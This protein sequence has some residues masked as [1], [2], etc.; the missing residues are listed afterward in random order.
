M[1]IQKHAKNTQNTQETHREITIQKHAKQIVKTQPTHR[2]ITIHR[3][4]ETHS[5]KHIGKLQPISMQNDTESTTAPQDDDNPEAC[6]KQHAKNIVKPQEKNQRKHSRSRNDPTDIA[7][8][9]NRP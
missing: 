8:G 5:E 9:R 4:A 1:T 6:Q 2:K 3:H 7:K